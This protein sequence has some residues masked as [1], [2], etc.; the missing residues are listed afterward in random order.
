MSIQKIAALGGG[1]GTL[2]SVFKLTNETDW[3]TKYDITIYQ[4]GWR[5][6]GKG[7]SGRNANIA[8]RIEEHGLHLWFGFYDNAFNVIQQ[9]YD[10]NG[11]EPGTP[12]A[13]W[14]EAFRGYDFISL[15]E[16]IN[17]EWL[18]WPFTIP[19]NSQTPG[20]STPLPSI[21]EYVPKIISLLFHQY[22]EFLSLNPHSNVQAKI[23]A[24][25][26]SPTFFQVKSK[27]LPIVMGVSDDILDDGGK[28]IFTASENL[29]KQ[30]NWPT[31]KEI[32]KDLLQWITDLGAGT[33]DLETDL[34]R[35]FIL[36]DMGTAT[37]KGMIDDQVITKGFDVI[38]QYD[39]RQWLGLHGAKPDTINSALV[40]G[41]YG[42]V[43]G[44]K[45]Q[46]TFEAGSALRGL[47]RLGLT[48]RGS[49]YYRM[50][51]G[52]G[53]VIFGPMYQVLTKRGVKF[54]F[55]HKITNLELD[56]Q[57]SISAIDMDVQASLKPAFTKYDPLVM[58]NGLPCWPNLPNNQFLAQ[59]IP[60]NVNLES[61]Y[62]K[63]P[64]ESQKKLVKGIDF[65]LVILGI[66]I[67]ALP[68]VASQLISKSTAWQKM[69]KNVI[70]VSTYAFQLWLKPNTTDM[71]WPYADKGLGLLGSYQEPF[72]TWADM[73]DLI[74]R[75]SWPTENTPKN[76]AYFCGPTPQPYADQILKNVLNSDF[77]DPGFPEKETNLAKNYALDYVQNLTK[78]IWPGIWENRTSFDFNTLI[79]LKNGQGEDRFNNQ[80]FRANIDPTELYVMS[81][82][83]SSSSRLKTDQ[84]STFPNLYITGDWIDNGF[85]AG[86]IE[87][88]VM[89]GL[90]TARA[91]SGEDFPISGEKDI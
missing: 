72:D 39:Y 31:L 54:E 71:K 59:P 60:D 43:F 87:A 33:P 41:V 45:E 32:L 17:N 15:E 56:E 89:A 48:Y 35:L 16:K 88:T 90:Q 3:K 1:M 4:M 74:D 73:S 47:L 34:R 70:A 12:L 53:D 62:S 83:N 55:F 44:G 46:Y 28:F 18:N 81:F 66:S 27:Y 14:E 37:I 79:D 38:N 58:V 26:S 86:C 30:L 21:A 7:A 65:D 63:Y 76:I 77:S 25:N 49:V 68:T 78:H 42:L 57:N 67:G 10:A 23:Q 29:S 24:Y 50:L 52:M 6:G 22:K 84:T 2:T 91:I 19:P 20:D 40:Q 8:Q 61:Y 69:I 85:N 75:E 80:F 5:L 13:T 36:I 82:T 51:A 9:V 64:P 11:R